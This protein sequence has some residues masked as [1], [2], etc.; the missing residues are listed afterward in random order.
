MRSLSLANLILVLAILLSAGCGDDQGAGAG[1][2]VAVEL[3]ILEPRTGAGLWVSLDSDSIELTE[4]L[5][6]RATTRWSDGVRVE[7]IEPNWEELGWSV[8][9]VLPGVVT[10]DGEGFE[11]VNEYVISPFLGGEYVID[12]FGIRAGSD[13]VGKRIARLAPLEVVV[14]SVLSESDGSEIEGAVELAGLPIEESD[15]GVGFIGVLAGLCVLLGVGGVVYARR[16]H[17]SAAETMDPESVVMI[18]AG[19]DQLSDEDIGQ[20]HRALIVLGGEHAGIDEIA[21][22]IELVR[23]SGEHMDLSRVREAAHRAAQICG[24]AG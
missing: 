8:E 17:A 22:E 4:A 21:Q 14:E 7:L 9:T 19:S 12:G 18:A 5:T 10:F 1:E 11:R 2:D 6:I 13:A 3:Q 23:F 16:Q 24:V 15:G 20:L